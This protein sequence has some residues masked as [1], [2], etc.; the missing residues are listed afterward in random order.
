MKFI[1]LTEGKKIL[2]KNFIAMKVAG[3]DSL[4]FPTISCGSELSFSPVFFLITGIK[5]IIIGKHNTNKKYFLIGIK[6][7]IKQ[8]GQN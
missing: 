3:E 4:K 1:S 2:M 6:R 5:N 8:C 7:F